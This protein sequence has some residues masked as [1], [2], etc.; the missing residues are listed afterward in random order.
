MAEHTDDT[1]LLAHRITGAGPTLVFLHGFTQTGSSW[2]QLTKEL[3]RDFTCVTVDLPGHGG[4][5]NGRRSLPETADGVAHV[6]EHLGNPAIVIGYSMGARVALHL[7]LAHP[8][9]VTGMVLVSGTAGISDDT[10]RTTRRHSDEALADR[11]ESIGTEVFL[12]EWLAQ[13]MFASLPPSAASITERLANTP[14]GLADSLRHAG[15]GT[16]TPLWSRLDEITVPTLIVTGDLDAKFTVLGEQLA[17][18][19]TSATHER[20]AGA[21]HTLH[22]EKPDTFIAALGGWLATVG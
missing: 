15:T 10:E 18:G 11:I 20:V 12:A 2:R 16:Q 21:G 7:A 17:A 5:P 22:L 8:R 13:P 9:L 6:I 1:G 14:A 4:S 3:S 19:I